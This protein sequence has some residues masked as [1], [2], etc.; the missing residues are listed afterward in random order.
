MFPDEEAEAAHEAAMMADADARRTQSEREETLAWCRE[1]SSAENTGHT[2]IKPGPTDELGRPLDDP[3]NRFDPDAIITRDYGRPVTQP[4]AAAPGDKDYWEKWRAFII[5][6]VSKKFV[7]EKM[8]GAVVKGMGKTISEW[9]AEVCALTKAAREEALGLLREEIKQLRIEVA[10]L[11][12][13]AE[14]RTR[15]ETADEARRIAGEARRQEQK[16]AQLRVA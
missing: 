12:A 16:A 2:R 14:R 3:R 11:R 8:L 15:P 6:T 7:S 9:D 10:E 13:A 4:Q 5:A 1:R